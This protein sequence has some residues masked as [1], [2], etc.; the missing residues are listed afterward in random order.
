MHDLVDTNRYPVEQ[1]AS[2]QYEALVNACR[3]SMA[4]IG[5][6]HLPGFVP[7]ATA[8]AMAS[9]IAPL[10]TFGRT[11]VLSA[12]GDPAGEHLAP[13]HIHRRLFPEDTQVLAGDQLQGT[14]LRRLYESSELTSFLADAL[15]LPMLHRFADP[16][17]DLNVVQIGDGGLHAWHYD[18]SDF[19]IT[20]LLQKSQVGGQF[21]FAPF[22]RGE[23]IPGVTGGRDGRVWDERY[24]DVEQLFDENWPDRELLDLEPGDLVMFNGLR[25]MH[26][27]RAVY[28]PTKRMIGVL[29]YDTKPGFRS[30]DAIN[31]RLY[32]PRCEAAIAQ[33]HGQDN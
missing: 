33:R 18:L 6:V 20:V 12:W 4:E 14:E 28:G 25:S 3:A 1:P 15:S 29:S 31:G 17:Q 13:D 22:I 10:P 32:G 11:H 27:V 26:R 23:V 21:E 24:D 16:F 30:T 8:R 19:V 2:E 9:E 7:S 5:C